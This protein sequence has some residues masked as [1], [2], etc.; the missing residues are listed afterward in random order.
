MREQNVIES[1]CGKRQ[2]ALLAVQA[3]RMVLRAV[4]RD[5]RCDS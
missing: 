3:A 2:Q 4:D 1:Y 5:P